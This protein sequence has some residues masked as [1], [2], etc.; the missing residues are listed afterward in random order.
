[1]PRSDASD[2]ANM[3]LIVLDK[4]N[5]LENHFFAGDPATTFHELRRFLFSQGVDSKLYSASKIP[6]NFQSQSGSISAGGVLGIDNAFFSEFRSMVA[7]EST[8]KRVVLNTLIFVLRVFM[9]YGGDGN[10]GIV[11]IMLNH[12]HDGIFEL[13]WVYSPLCEFLKEHN[14][15]QHS[16]SE[17]AGYLSLTSNMVF[18]T[19]FRGVHEFTS[20]YY[21][22]KPILEYHQMV[23]SNLPIESPF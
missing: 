10:N 23:G 19:R 4:A 11:Q 13:N 14:W 16:A 20:M 6:S 2:A 8:E 5:K 17:Q 1:M 9:D 15:E 22:L 7:V 18:E 21:K 12:L 3:A